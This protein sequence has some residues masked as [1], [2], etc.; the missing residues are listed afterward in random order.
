MLTISLSS[1]LDGFLPI[2][3]T[4]T[5]DGHSYSG[6]AHMVQYPLVILSSSAVPMSTY[7]SLIIRSMVICHDTQRDDISHYGPIL[8][9]LQYITNCRIMLTK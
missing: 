2:L 7:L 9:L 4:K 3:Q 1:Y 6:V 5:V 8:S